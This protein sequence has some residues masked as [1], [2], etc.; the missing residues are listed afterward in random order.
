MNRWRKEQINRYMH[1]QGAAFDRP[2]AKIYW[3]ERDKCF[4]AESPHSKVRMPIFEAGLAEFLEK[5]GSLEPDQVAEIN[6]L[7]GK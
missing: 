5:F 3:N 4:I 7:K 2:V 1:V 6:R